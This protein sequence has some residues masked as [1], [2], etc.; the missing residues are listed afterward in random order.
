MAIQGCVV[1]RYDMHDANPWPPL[2]PFG[3][4]LRKFKAWL[5]QRPWISPAA[6]VRWCGACGHFEG[7][8]PR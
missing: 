1:F 8:V 5:I 6:R 4:M 7:R 2:T 3:A